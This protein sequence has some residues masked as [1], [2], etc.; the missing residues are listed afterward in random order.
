VL[1]IKDLIK[2]LEYGVAGELSALIIVF[3]S[4]INKF[5]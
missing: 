5:E 1:E 2:H 4:R 3:G